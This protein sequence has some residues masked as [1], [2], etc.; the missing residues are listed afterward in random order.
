MEAELRHLLAAGVEREET[1]GPWH[2]RFLT[3]DGVPL[4]AVCS[5][6]GMVN[7]AAATE[8]LI[9]VHRPGLILNFGCAGAHRRD[10]LPGDV[11]IGERSVHHAA[12]HILANGEELFV[13]GRYE[14]GGET[15][16][17]ADLASD[18]ALVGLARDAAAGWAPDAWPAAAGWPTDLARRA[19]TVHVGAVA[20]ADVWTQ[21]PARLDLLHAR[22]GTLCEDM[23]AAAIAQVCVRHGVP[24]LT[25]KDISNNEF[26]A[27]SDLAGGFTDFP[28]AE[29]GKRAAALLRR[30]VA[31]LAREP[32]SG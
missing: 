10:I 25:I 5:G 19:A 6:M 18:P 17:A 30:V 32:V 22:H 15:M 13:G 27:A 9:G 31:R 28:T 16:E 4:V 8:R 14:V 21:A 29:V 12:V 20:S 3:I 26:H 23:E 2:D 11:V 7:A 24:F 1:D